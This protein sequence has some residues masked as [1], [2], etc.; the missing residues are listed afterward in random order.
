MSR[1]ARNPSV[2]TRGAVGLSPN[3]SR[4]IGDFLRMTRRLLENVA[5]ASESVASS[6]ENVASPFESV[7]VT[8]SG[9]RVSLRGCRVSLR[10]CRVGLREC[11][12]G[13][14]DRSGTHSIRFQ[15]SFANSLRA[16]NDHPARGSKP[17]LS[18]G[19]G[20]VDT[21]AAS[22]GI[23]AVHDCIR[24]ESRDNLG[25]RRHNPKRLARNSVRR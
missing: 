2:V 11:R 17:D 18:F 8:V 1:F 10:E 4:M 21:P 13:L 22:N 5:S 12:V 16:F 25:G 3:P 6:L 24:R 20:C 14:R 23:R 9:C 15:S 19:H 7:A